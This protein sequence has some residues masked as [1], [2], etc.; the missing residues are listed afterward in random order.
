MSATDEFDNLI[1]STLHDSVRE[2][3]PSARVWGRIVEQIKRDEAAA[4]IAAQ[5]EIDNR[6]TLR[7]E[8]RLDGFDL[9]RS[10]LPG[11]GILSNWIRWTQLVH[12]VR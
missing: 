10:D 1:H 9:S 6:H 11:S 8:S 3:Q 5:P 12:Q 2:A 7:S 4:R